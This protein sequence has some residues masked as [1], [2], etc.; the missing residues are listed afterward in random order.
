MNKLQQKQKKNTLRK[1]LI[2]H[3]AGKSFQY[4]RLYIDVCYFCYCTLQCEL[5]VEV[6]Y[7]KE[8]YI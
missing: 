7:K 4:I 5:C 3:E 6:R 2:N 8:D 1:Q